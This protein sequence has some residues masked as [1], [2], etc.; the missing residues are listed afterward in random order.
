MQYLVTVQEKG[1]GSTITVF[2]SLRGAE[3]HYMEAVEFGA[4]SCFIT[5]VMQ[6]RHYGKIYTPKGRPFELLLSNELDNAI[7][8]MQGYE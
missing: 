2:D 1:R 4:M 6:G 8:S 5:A 7:E 3:E